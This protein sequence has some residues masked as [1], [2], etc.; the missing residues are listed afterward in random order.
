MDFS[1]ERCIQ[2]DTERMTNNADLDQNFSRSSLILLYTVFLG[3]YVKKMSGQARG[4]KLGQQI[5]DDY[6]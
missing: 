4:L 2:K 1:E 5:G 3:L 6:L